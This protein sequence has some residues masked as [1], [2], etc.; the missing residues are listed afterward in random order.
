MRTDL[1]DVGDEGEK[2]S[3]DGVHVA[4][5]VARVCERIAR[6]AERAGKQSSDVTLIAVTKT[7]SVSSV[8]AAVNAGVTH[9]GE[10]YVQEARAKVDEVN[11]KVKEAL[12]W[13]FIG[14]LQSN[15]AKYVTPLFDVV[16]TIDRVSLAE[17]LNKQATKSGKKQSV[18]IEVNLTE[19]THRGGV[20]P[21]QLPELVAQTT[22]LP[23]LRLSGLMGVP[24]AMDTAEQA[25]VHFAHLRKLW[26]GLPEESRR[27]LS[28]GMSGNFE[29]AIEEGA[30]HVRLGTA[31]FG[32]RNKG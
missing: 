26:D 6:A 11:A 10:N 8:L 31:L 30:T 1:A 5:A 20:A 25:R 16:Q 17:E 21:E 3:S 28:M 7:V 15:K 18:L 24:P 29:Q 12:V 9:F 23:S 14:Q 2:N 19:E 22:E 13:H 32:S 27:I 4:D